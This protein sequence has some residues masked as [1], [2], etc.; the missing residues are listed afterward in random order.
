MTASSYFSCGARL[1]A[2]SQERILPAQT[3]KAREV[4]VRRAEQEPMLDS[5]SSEM[6]IR[7]QV[8]VI[9]VIAHQRPQDLAMPICWL[10]NP[11]NRAAQP[12][13]DL[14]PGAGN[15]L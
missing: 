5:E 15:R 13:L 14:L 11:D 2:A 6:G 8:R 3:G 1:M 7:H 4:A 12:L 9:D 10:R